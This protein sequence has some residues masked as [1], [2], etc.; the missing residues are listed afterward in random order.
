MK[1]RI[2]RAAYMQAVILLSTFALSMG[3]RAQSITLY[4]D[5]YATQYGVAVT[6]LT[7]GQ[8]VNLSEGQIWATNGF[9]QTYTID[10]SEFGADTY[11]VILLDDGADGGLSFEV[12][13]DNLPFVCG[14][15]C[16]G[17]LSVGPAAAFPFSL[18]QLDGI[19]GCMDDAACNFDPNAGFNDGSCCYDS[20]IS[21]RLYDAFSNGWVDGQGN[22]GGATVGNLAGQELGSIQF[23]DG[24]LAVLDLC[25]VDDCYVLELE[26]DNLAVEASWEIYL[27][28]QLILEGG[29][30]VA[31]ATIQEFFYVGSSRLFECG[32]HD[33]GCL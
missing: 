3:V 9:N 5:F 10:L 16:S 15:S 29:P 12:N 1:L 26:F 17:E 22:I 32:L 11:T 14:G 25:L 31:G 30:G 20:C 18:T 8:I 6:S 21:V 13:V 23:S 28:E 24:G 2:P 33:R 27:G 19:P 4:S 7:Q